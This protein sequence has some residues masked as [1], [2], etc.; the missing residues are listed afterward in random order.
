VTGIVC[1]NGA[2][3][4]PLVDRLVDV[5]RAAFA[6]APFHETDVEAGWF[7][8][9]L[10]TE[11]ELDG[12]R[13]CVAR[14]GEDLGGF[15]YGFD[16]PATLPPD[17]W[18]SSLLD[19]VGPEAAERWVLGQFAVG[20]LAVRPGLQGQGLGRRL[21]RRVL[22]GTTKR[23]AWLV[24]HDLES[25]AMALYRSLGWHEIGRGPLGWHAAERVVLAAELQPASA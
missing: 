18:Y 19:A 1:L 8:R 21:F 20:W 17:S 2:R 22:A 11:L 25:T 10:A 9:E 7:A 13:C 3:T 23:R 16:T 14:Q 15:A 24:A 12:F 5:Y 4:A 6:P